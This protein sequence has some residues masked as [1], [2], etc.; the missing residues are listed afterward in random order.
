MPAT[1]YD[2]FF[3]EA[4]DK[5]SFALDDE[6]KEYKSLTRTLQ[7]LVTR[8]KSHNERL[9]LENYELKHS[10]VGVPVEVKGQEP[11]PRPE[12]ESDETECE[13]NY[14]AEEH[15]SELEYILAEE[16][17]AAELDQEAE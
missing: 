4:R 2:Q 15:E 10:N 7:N 1:D 17:L 9:K 16:T 8:L 11:T 13:L 3:H 5:E 14:G 6:L 12:Q